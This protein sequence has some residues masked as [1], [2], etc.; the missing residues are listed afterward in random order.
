[1]L[2]EEKLDGT[3]RFFSLVNNGGKNYGTLD[4]RKDTRQGEKTAGRKEDSTS[5]T[6]APADVGGSSR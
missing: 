6:S 4:H 1:M 2:I 3:L 5:S